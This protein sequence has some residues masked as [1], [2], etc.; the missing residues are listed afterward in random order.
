MNS[1]IQ[2]IDVAVP[3]AGDRDSRLSA[4][5]QVGYGMGQLLDGASSNAVN[6]FL[7]FYLTAV[8]GMSGAAAGMAIAAGLVV[9]A[10]ADPVIG[11]LS[12]GWQSR[13]GRRLPF[14]LAGILPASFSLVLLFSLPTQASGAALFWL[15]MMVSLLLRLSIS[16]FNLPYLALGAEV[17]DDHNERMT[18]TA[19]RWGLGM[20]AGLTSVM[21]GFGV[22][23]KG[24]DGLMHRSAYSGFGLACAALM[25]GGAL[26]SIF[27]GHRM[28]GRTHD[29]ATADGSQR[30]HFV[31]GVIELVRNP[32]FRVL[33][34]S[35]LLFFI[36][37]GLW[38]S[39][40]LHANTFF[41]ELD[42]GETQFVTL[43]LFVGLLLG[44]PMAGLFG[45]F[46][47]RTAMLVGVAGMMLA[48]AAP[49]VLRL[50]GLLP[51]SHAPLAD[52]LAAVSLFNG[53]MGSVIAVALGA[54]MADAADE[55]EFLF[56]ARREG[57]YFAGWAFAAK[58]SAGIGTLLAGMI[59]QFIGFPK[60]LAAAGGTH[61]VLSA[62]TV[63]LLGVFVGPGAASIG[64]LGAVIIFGYRLSRRRHAEI[65]LRLAERH[66]DASAIRP[67]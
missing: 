58:T 47:K 37:L 56:R 28:R 25:T 46:E 16:L 5:L 40:G 35:S 32:S 30:A 61:A 27:A 23:L 6:I 48:M 52:V 51:L 38:L 50:A 45:R 19:W 13:W 11:F 15:V 31:A 21:L 8:C 55:H 44:A 17:T 62:H 54:M 29:I 22:F 57:L 67:R 49:V 64:M 2:L 3:A 65:L 24:P 42:N 66:A 36:S 20:A 14:M 12:D 26:I 63:T 4:G 60:G 9:D 7:L 39:L 41:W 43:S 59:L 33:F 1:K 10:V 18:L 53:A 34:A